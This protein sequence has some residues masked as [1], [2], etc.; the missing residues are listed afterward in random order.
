MQVFGEA[1]R[2]CA[3][4]CVKNPELAAKYGNVYEITPVGDFHFYY[5]NQIAD[6]HDLNWVKR[7][8]YSGKEFDEDQAAALGIRIWTSDKT[9][10]EELKNQ[11]CWFFEISPEYDVLN[12]LLENYPNAGPKFVQDFYSKGTCLEHLKDVK[13]F[14]EILLICD[15][16]QCIKLD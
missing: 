14:S 5:S 16:I 7:Q 3:A 6:L 4:F 10:D 1:A 8:I 2:D 9:S 12:F 13:H 11:I 15:E